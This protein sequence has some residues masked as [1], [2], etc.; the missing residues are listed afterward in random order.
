MI[1]RI[2]DIHLGILSILKEGF[3]HEMLSVSAKKSKDAVASY[4]KHASVREQVIKGVSE[5]GSRKLS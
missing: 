1:K 3:F 2:K 4:L 5:L